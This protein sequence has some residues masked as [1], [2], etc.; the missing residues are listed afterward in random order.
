MANR[1]GEIDFYSSDLFRHWRSFGT[2]K[3]PFFI[4]P[5]VDPAG[6]IASVTGCDASP[7]P[8]LSIAPW[9]CNIVL[10]A[11]WLG[12]P[13]VMHFATCNSGVAEISRQAAGL[14]I[15]ASDK[16]LDLLLAKTLAYRTFSNGAV[17]LVQ[18]RISADAYKFSWQRIDAITEFWLSRET[19][20]TGGEIAPLRSRLETVCE[21]FSQ[22]AELI[23]PIADA[24]INWYEAA[25]LPREL[26]HGDFWLGNVLFKGNEVAGIIDWEWATPDGIRMVDML[27]MLLFSK[28]TERGESFAL[29]L[30]K[31]WTDELEDEEITSRIRRVFAPAGMDMEDAKFLGLALWFEILWQRTVPESLFLRAWVEDMIPQTAPVALQWLMRRSMA[32]PS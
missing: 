6:A 1:Q 22:Y 13:A 24:L 21:F 2:V 9:H 27:H 17:L 19:V 11:N 4:V 15:A 26:S 32:H 16:Q 14:E 12:E 5:G 31:F 7:I 23:S 10:Q 3:R 25:Q 18:S 29:Y 28:A 30:R 20:V 8:R